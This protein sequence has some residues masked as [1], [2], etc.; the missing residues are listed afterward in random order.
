MF[1]LRR[2][3]R[4]RIGLLATLLTTFFLINCLKG[5]LP[6]TSQT[7]EE[8]KTKG[9][10]FVKEVDCYGTEG[11]IEVW[12]DPSVFFMEF[13]TNGTRSMG[14]FTFRPYMNCADQE[15]NA[16]IQLVKSDYFVKA[17]KGGLKLKE[18]WGKRRPNQQA[19][20]VIDLVY[21]NQVPRNG[22]FIEAGAVDGDLLS[23]TLDFEV[24]YG[25]TG[26]LAEANP[27]FYNSLIDTNR[28][29]IN[30]H[31]C[32]GVKTSPHYS[33]FNFDSAVG[34]NREDGLKSMGGLSHDLRRS[35]QMQC[36]PLYTLLKAAG[37]PTVNLLVLDVE[38]AELYVLKTIPWEKVDIE[39]MSIET[40]LI[41]EALPGGSQDTI[42]KY[43]ENL[44][45]V[46]FPHRND[47]NLKTGLQQ[48]DLFVRQDIVRKYNV[49]GYPLS[50]NR[51]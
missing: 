5:A 10:V 47:F 4:W 46:R 40:D 15:E 31:T 7:D 22:F 37:N 13:I 51:P 16:L 42:R 50:K 9:R 20:D 38:G 17:K 27:G 48:N 3:F 25:W 26:I 49:N 36:I 14:K 33:M 35:M 1:G 30:V 12:K 34:T 23:V 21:R 11:P 44:G 24:K 43:V 8:I 2:Q 6:E 29:A 18:P 19:K 39:V 41:G 45:Y 28:N 32:L